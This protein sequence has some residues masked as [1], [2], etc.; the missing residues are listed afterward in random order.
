MDNTDLNNTNDTKYHNDTVPLPANSSQENKKWKVAT[1]VAAVVAV[2]GIGLNIFQAINGQQDD[3]K[4]ASLSSEI[5][6]LQEQLNQKTSDSMQGS[7]MSDDTQHTSIESSN[8]GSNVDDISSR[9]Y[10][11]PEGWNARFAY[12]NGVTNVEYH[13]QDD[14]WDGELVIDGVTKDGK[15]YDADLFG[16]KESYRHYP[17]FFAQV[18]RWNDVNPRNSW[19][20]SIV[21]MD[22]IFTNGDYKYYVWDK[23]NGYETGDAAAYNEACQ[24][25]R[26]LLR[27]IEAR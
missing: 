20:G 26:E 3:N 14:L 12:P 2:L 4:I 15:T 8:G 21:N 17:F 10:L 16:G 24:I 13:V 25:V 9:K 19:S 23:G 1:I 11:E 27:N 22:L 7:E 18:A 5:G 6:S